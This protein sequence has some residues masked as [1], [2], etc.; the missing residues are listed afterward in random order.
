MIWSIREESL[1]YYYEYIQIIFGSKSSGNGLGR[2]ISFAKQM[3]VKWSKVL[4]VQKIGRGPI[5]ILDHIMFMCSGTS[6]GLIII[7]G[8]FIE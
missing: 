8:E 7:K 1:S 6:V 4:I 3:N 2:F 5:T